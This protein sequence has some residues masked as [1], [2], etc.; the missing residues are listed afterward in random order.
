MSTDLALNNQG[1]EIEVLKSDRWSDEDFD[2]LKGGGGFLPALTLFIAQSQAVQDGK[3]GMNMYGLRRSGDEIDV[4]DKEVDIVILN[5]R[6]KALDLTDKNNIRASFD[7]KSDLFKEIQAKANAKKTEETKH[8]RCMFGYEFLVWVPD[9]R[10]FAAFFMG[11]PT[12]RNEAGKVLGRMGDKATLKSKRIDGAQNSW[13]GPV[14]LPCSAIFDLPDQDEARKVQEEFL[15][16]KEMPGKEVVKN[17][18]STTV[19]R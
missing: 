11:S 10:E 5:K 6:P 3:I 7:P 12:A 8:L 15:D 17:N 13:Y 16:P 1:S 9:R 19:E 18:V 14:C 2:G 4:L